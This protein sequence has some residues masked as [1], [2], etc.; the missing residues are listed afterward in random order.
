MEI[1]NKT[2][3]EKIDLYNKLRLLYNILNNFISQTLSTS[4]D[5]KVKKLV[6]NFK[7]NLSRFIISKQT[8][9][10]NFGILYTNI[11]TIKE[12]YSDITINEKDKLKL[13]SYFE[14]EIRQFIKKNEI[15]FDYSGNQTK[16]EENENI[17]FSSKIKEISNLLN[18][19]IILFNSIAETFQKTQ[20]ETKQKLIN[21]VDKDYQNINNILQKIRKYI[22]IIL[23]NE[24]NFKSLEQIKLNLLE[25]K[26]KTKSEIEIIKSQIQNYI[27]QGDEYMKMVT[28]YKRLCNMIDCMK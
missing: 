15:L 18:D 19:N 22:F 14:E 11:S 2:I 20:S 25:R 24:Q 9:D 13:L 3:N 7:S 6:G 8:K 4:S 21:E 26:K 28:E 23:S 16:S 17:L 27:N 12:Q 10:E 1:N 5:E